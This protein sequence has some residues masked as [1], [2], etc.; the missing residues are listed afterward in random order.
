[1]SEQ[2][3]PAA[4][5]VLSLREITV[6]LYFEAVCRFVAR[7]VFRGDRPGQFFPQ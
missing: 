1:M 7:D 2:N 5:Y 4:E 3:L 6:E